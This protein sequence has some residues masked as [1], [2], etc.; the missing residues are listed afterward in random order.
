MRRLQ[1]GVAVEAQ[2]KETIS[3]LKE[4]YP[5]AK[6]HDRLSPIQPLAFPKGMIRQ[7]DPDGRTISFAVVPDDGSHV[8]KLVEQA[9]VDPVAFDAALA[10]GW[11]VLNGNQE[12]PISL[13]I[14]LAEYLLGDR[15]RPKGKRGPKSAAVAHSLRYQV[16]CSQIQRLVKIGFTATRNNESNYED[17]AC[18]IV[19]KA[20]KR[21]NLRPS[22]YSQIVDIWGKRRNFF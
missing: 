13:R 8:E 10:R 22:S 14:F 21:L 19:A 17:S 4:N 7:V 2:I 5:W 16:I 15:L 6:R 20:M 9:A 3:E 18:D 1:T 11:Y 12:I